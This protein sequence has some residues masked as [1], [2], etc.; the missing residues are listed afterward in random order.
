MEERYTVSPAK[1]LGYL[2]TISPSLL[3]I[4]PKFEL[5]KKFTNGS[6]VFVSV[7]ITTPEILKYSFTTVSFP[8]L[9]ESIWLKEKKGNNHSKKNNYKILKK[10]KIQPILRQ[11]IL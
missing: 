10:L 8:I 11:H 7:C 4:V 1:S 6:F 5:V 3:D 2:N 9:T